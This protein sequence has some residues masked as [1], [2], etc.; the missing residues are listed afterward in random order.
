VVP[1]LG[2]VILEKG[3]SFAPVR[4]QTP[5]YPA[6]LETP[7]TIILPDLCR[8]KISLLLGRLDHISQTF[9]NKVVSKIFD[10]EWD[11]IRQQFMVLYT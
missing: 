2:L 11:K 5:D 8:C 3:K 10:N 7:K 1:R 4:N 9:G 6:Q